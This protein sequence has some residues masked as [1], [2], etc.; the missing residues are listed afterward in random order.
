M[1]YRNVSIQMIFFYHFLF[2]PA[3][4][5]KAWHKNFL[6]LCSSIPTPSVLL[7]KVQGNYHF[8]PVTT[9]QVKSSE[10][11]KNHGKL[12]D[13]FSAELSGS[14]DISVLFWCVQYLAALR[15]S[16]SNKDNSWM[17]LWGV[18]PSFTCVILSTHACSAIL[19]TR[20][21]SG[22]ILL[23]P[24]WYFGIF[25]RSYGGKDISNMANGLAAAQSQSHSRLSN[26]T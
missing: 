11:T 22:N 17:W 20:N 24:S 18:L 19:V 5:C 7:G 4:K 16:E 12:A 14:A 3:P 23:S 8:Y 15:L 10:S 25:F 26:S 2:V 6:S 1:C 21:L 9:C 13:L